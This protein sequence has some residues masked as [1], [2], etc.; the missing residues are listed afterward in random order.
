MGGKRGKQ[1]RQPAR[2][3]LRDLSSFVDESDHLPSS[4]YDP[5]SHQDK[6]SGA[7]EEEDDRRAEEKW[8]DGPPSKFELYQRS[9]QVLIHFLSSKICGFSELVF[10]LA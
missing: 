9:V 3:R 8:I 2:P 6:E 4:A 5:P 7:S 1:Q 10:V